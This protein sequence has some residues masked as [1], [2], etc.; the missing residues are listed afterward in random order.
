M[1]FPNSG[2]FDLSTSSVAGA[3]KHPPSTGISWPLFLLRY[4]LLSLSHHPLVFGD[5][6]YYE[7]NYSSLPSETTQFLHPSVIPL[8]RKKVLGPIALVIVSIHKGSK[9]SLNGN[10]YRFMNIHI[11]TPPGQGIGSLFCVRTANYRTLPDHL[12]LKHLL[13]FNHTLSLLCLAQDADAYKL[14]APWVPAKYLTW[15]SSLHHENKVH[16]YPTLEHIQT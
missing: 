7:D 13:F 5:K 2:T 11:S 9:P 15:L 16:L 6:A 8:S 4:I 14:D 3:R 10:G 1:N 12:Y